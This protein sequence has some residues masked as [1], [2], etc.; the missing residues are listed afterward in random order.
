MTHEK[1]FLHR[2]GTAYQ[3]C[4]GIAQATRLCR[5]GFGN[6]GIPVRHFQTPGLSVCAPSR[7][8]RQGGFD[9]TEKDRFHGQAIPEPRRGTSAMRE[10]HRAK[11]KRYRHRGSGGVSLQGSGAWLRRRTVGNRLSSNIALTDSQPTRLSRLTGFWCPRG[12]GLG[13]IETEV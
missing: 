10:I 7:G 9:S 8:H 1:I 4:P 12:S 2:T 11:L 13:V 5:Q 3:C 6:N